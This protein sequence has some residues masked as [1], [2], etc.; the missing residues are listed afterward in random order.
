MEAIDCFICMIRSIL[1]FFSK[2]TNQSKSSVQMTQLIECGE[3]IHFKSES[4]RAVLGYTPPII[5]TSPVFL[6]HTRQEKYGY[7]CIKTV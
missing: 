4:G 5:T 1:V 6:F 7:L 2:K 3:N